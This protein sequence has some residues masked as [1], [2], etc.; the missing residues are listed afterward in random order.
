MMG[1]LA[2]DPAAL[3]ESSR[4]VLALQDEVIRN[5]KA[6]VSRQLA[7][8][9]RLRES[10]LENTLPVLYESVALLL[11]PACVQRAGIDISVMAVGH[12]DERARLTGY[13]TTTLIHELQLFR[14]SF[15]DTVQGAGVALSADQAGMIHTAID[16]AIRESANAFAS[17][18]AALREQFAVALAHDLR[19]PLSNAHLAAQLIERASSLEQARG[20]AARILQN[21]GRIEDMTT[22]LLDNLLKVG[23]M[24]MPMRIEQF[25][26]SELAAEVVQHT[27]TF[28]GVDLKLDAAPVSGHWCRGS[29]H[30]AIENLVGNAIKHGTAGAPVQLWVQQTAVRVKVSVHNEGDPIPVE[31]MESIFQLYLRAEEARRSSVGWGV[32]LPFVRRVAEAH[33][34]TVLVSSTANEGTTFSIDIPRDARPFQANVPMLG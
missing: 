28:R 15:M 23:G 32:G 2:V 33:G 10:I 3:S 5:W 30:R 27:S 18:Q 16:S 26:M 11:T 29:L 9:S 8:A 19:T 7:E 6:L 13:D 25:D 34:G 17:A 12:G 4:Q 31:M 22:Q 24:S 20:L 21:T 1:L 14:R